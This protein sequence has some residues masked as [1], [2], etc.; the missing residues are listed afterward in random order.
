M[1]TILASFR[2]KQLLFIYL[3]FSSFSLFSQDWLNDKEN[4]KG[5]VQ[6]VHYK[7]TRFMNDMTED[8]WTSDNFYSYNSNGFLVK[9]V[10]YR[11]MNG[12]EY[13]ATY[14]IYNQDENRC[15]VQYYIEEKDTSS[16]Y[17]FEYDNLGRTEKVTFYSSGWHWSTF[18]YV[19]NEA[20]LVK[21]CFAVIQRDNDTIRNKYEYDRFGNKIKDTHLSYSSDLVKTWL[22][23]ENGNLIEEKSVL[24]K[25]GNT[26]IYTINTDGSVEKKEIVG[27]NPYDDDNYVINY[28]YNDN[29]QIIKEVKS[30][31]DDS[32]QYN[33]SFTYYENGEINTKCYLNPKDDEKLSFEYKY[34]SEG[35]WI[36]KTT[37][38]NGILDRKEE[39]EIT[40]Y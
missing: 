33:V 6:S 1:K 19:Y 32:I 40:Y 38:W 23:D 34:D 25:A 26:I 10:L 5:E 12:P 22:Y 17:L 11:S 20:G 37:Y 31:L 13:D 4:L 16:K 15:L 8:L 18:Y 27:I 36:L 24:I 7:S 29:H 28:A 39:R 3:A 21:E 14:R 35:N 9:S 30:Y 2:M